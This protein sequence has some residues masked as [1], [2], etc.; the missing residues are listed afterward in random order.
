MKS[1]AKER[2]KNWKSE[3]KNISEL[4]EER[5]RKAGVIESES[6]HESG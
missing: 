3:N 1:R 2:A 4:K 6:E 5:M